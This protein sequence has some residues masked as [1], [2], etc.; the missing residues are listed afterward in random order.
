MAVTVRWSVANPEW[1]ARVRSGAYQEYYDRHYDRRS[2]WVQG[3]EAGG[4]S[5]TSNP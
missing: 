3:V 2:A 5:E 4:V 1:V